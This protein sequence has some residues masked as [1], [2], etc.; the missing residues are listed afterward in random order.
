M[1]IPA[2]FLLFFV[3]LSRDAFGRSTEGEADR[4]TSRKEAV[5]DA[6]EALTPWG[7]RSW[8]SERRKRSLFIESQGRI[9]WDQG[10]SVAYTPGEGARV[11]VVPQAP[12]PALASIPAAPASSPPS[13]ITRMVPVFMSSQFGGFSDFEG[14]F[15][16]GSG[17]GFGGFAS[18]D[19]HPC[20]NMCEV[21]NERGGCDVN[22][23]CFFI[24]P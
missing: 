10:S 22:V 23:T 9:Q 5:E 2:L 12:S 16:G 24:K 3:L 14:G 20:I 13:Y 8:L 6:G 4:K 18:I 17:G 21:R 7:P 11:P 1:E 15:G 19:S